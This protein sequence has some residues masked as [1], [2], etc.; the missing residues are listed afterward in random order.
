MHLRQKSPVISA[1]HRCT[2]RIHEGTKRDASIFSVYLPAFVWCR[3]PRRAGAI[4]D[5]F[6]WSGPSTRRSLR[7]W[8]RARYAGALLLLAVSQAVGDELRELFPGRVAPAD[9]ER[10]PGRVCVH[11]VTLGGI[12]VRSCLQQ[13]GAQGHRLVVRGSWVLDVE[14]EMTC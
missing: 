10:M 5:L 6:P 8:S 11:L 12:E 9:A 2:S 14:I 3:R 1:Y 13:P 4:L 7:A